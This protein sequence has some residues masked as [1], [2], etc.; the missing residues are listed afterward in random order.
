MIRSSSN[1]DNNLGLNLPTDTQLD[2]NFNSG[3]AITPQIANFDS[4]LGITSDSFIES[5]VVSEQL[6]EPTYNY[7][8][9][10]NSNSIWDSNRNIFSTEAIDNAIDDF[11]TGD[12][13]LVNRDNSDVTDKEINFLDPGIERE[14]KSNISSS[15]VPDLKL[16]NGLFDRDDINIITGEGQPIP[17]EQSDTDLVGNSFAQAKDLGTI[18]DTTTFSESV[19]NQDPIDFYQFNLDT[20][21][22]VEF[23][24]SGLSADA[25]IAIFD[26]NRNRLAGSARTGTRNEYK[27][28]P[29]LAAG[30]YYVKVFQKEG[31][32]NYD[33]TLDFEAANVDL[34]GNS[35]AQAKDLGIVTDT[36]TFSES[37][38]NQDPV[39]FY[40][41]N[42]NTE[43]TVEFNL[44]GLSADANITIFDGN[45]NR[46]AGS[47]RTG[48]RNEYKAVPDLAAGDYYVK[49]F[50]KSGN[51]D[52][53]LTLSLTDEPEITVTYPN[54]GDQLEA[55]T[56]YDITWTD[57]IDE[58]VNIDLYRDDTYVQTIVANT[59]SDGL[60]DWTVPTN[61]PISDRYKIKVSQVGDNSISDLSD[62]YFSIEPKEISNYQWRAD[63]FNNTN[64][65]GDSVFTEYLGNGEQNLSQ[66][67]DRN[68]PNSRINNDYFSA[69]ITTKRDLEAGWYQ[70]QSGSDDGIRVIVDDRL[71]INSWVD[72]GFTEDSDY[73]HFYFDGGETE[74]KIEYYDKTGIAALDFKLQEA[75][76]FESGTF[77]ASELIEHRI[78]LDQPGLD[79]KIEHTGDFNGDGT[80]DVLLRNDNGLIHT[81]LLDNNAKIIDRVNLEHTSWDWNIEQVGDFNGDG[82]DDVLIRRYDGQVH[83]WLLENAQIKSR[84]DLEHTSWDW[85][86]EQV[87]DFNGDGTDDVLIRRFDGRVHSWLLENAQIKSRVDLEHTSWDWNI[88]QVGDL[89]EDGTTDIIN[90]KYN[91]HVH[92]WLLN[93]HGGI[94]NRVDLEH[95]S[96]DWNI[97]GTGDFNNDGTADVLI[98]RY[99]GR[100]HTWLLK[101][102]H[103][104]TDCD[105]EYDYY[106]ELA[107]LSDDDWDRQSG[108]NILFD[109]NLGNGE[110]RNE[111]KAI[112][113]DLLNT[114]FGGNHPMSAGY[115]HD[116][117][118][119]QGI[120]W[121]HD[122]IDIAAPLGTEARMAVD[123]E[124]VFTNPDY[125]G[126]VTVKDEQGKYHIYKHLDTIS[127]SVGQQ[128]NSGDKVGTVGGRGEGRYSF[129]SHLHYEILNSEYANGGSS[130]YGSVNIGAGLYKNESDL[131][132]VTQ[133]PLQAFWKFKNDG[134]NHENCNNGGG[135][136]DIS[137][138]M[139]AVPSDYRNSTTRNNITKIL[140][141]ASEAGL[142]ES[143]VAYVLATVQHET[144][145]QF[146]P[147]SEAYWLDD[148]NT[149]VDEADIYLRDTYPYSRYYPYYGRG[150]VQ[151]TWEG[152]Y[153]DWSNRLG[154]DFVG[155]PDLA[156]NPDFA[157]Q[158]LV[159]G[160]RDGTF[161][162]LG[163]D[164]Y[165]NDAGIDF[166]NARR[167]VNG[168]DRAPLIA[169]YANNYYNALT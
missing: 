137:A 96:F 80:D 54:G 43:G 62:N 20:E 118:Y 16:Q 106:P 169:G 144:A 59:P 13:L 114:V 111:T 122:G 3:D 108:D 112:F 90:R 14:N 94:A 163:L 145:H 22:T 40:Q 98:R 84:V 1:E 69:R 155:N 126:V 86:I 147:V 136:F 82:T 76:D 133:S 36:T 160:M 168:T 23:N 157:S 64:L 99:D 66:N 156:N 143:Q 146:Q 120:G 101:D 148:P 81:W 125:F 50:Q 53:D 97:Q 135:D 52:Y 134:I 65:S 31:D 78:D 105:H 73:Q 46:L 110:S 149:P 109:G 142:S 15:T 167:I 128:I 74:I 119:L 4:S 83:S 95:T 29:D 41:F 154:Q 138:V 150:Y 93:E 25:N 113:G 159:Y 9:G 63:Y 48:T 32:T 51:T 164:R 61:L 70:V 42:L 11:S 116:Y 127:V 44:S 87:G 45:R 28:V 79:W 107:S 71:I 166:I 33:L 132:E 68:S 91:G 139:T 77:P 103:T 130:V 21:G 158:I 24:L 60:A 38:G 2:N 37:V 30:D 88:E 49:V 92:A 151:L 85:N 26:G 10:L 115:I 5:E 27:A 162:G 55:G 18:T 19:G 34:A 7:S 131:K 47:A 161:T 165:I 102:G 141:V 72:R 8:D 117:S 17:I 123:G 104:G 56:D 67:W 35:F 12:L 153:Q 129:G 6:T 121:L 140:D 39:D 58:N 75:K 124:V 100:V 57:N 152:N 89:N